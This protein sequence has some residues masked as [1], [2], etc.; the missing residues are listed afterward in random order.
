MDEVGYMNIW[1]IYMDKCLKE[2]R[3]SRTSVNALSVQG[4]AQ[5]QLLRC[6]C[7][8]IGGTE[9]SATTPCRHRNSLSLS[10]TVSRGGTLCASFSLPSFQVRQYSPTTPHPS[11]PLCLPLANHA[12]LTLVAVTPAGHTD[13]VLA[14]I[15]LEA[16]SK[17]RAD[18]ARVFSASL[19]NTICCWD[20]YDMTCIYKYDPLSPPPRLSLL[21]DA[22]RHLMCSLL[23]P[24]PDSGRRPLRSAACC[25]FPTVDC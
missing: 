2:L 1:N 6:V 19:D 9:H 18:D 13:A 12:A 3:I 7:A 5:V 11:L 17:D 20:P 15:H 25:T 14:L 10:A 24:S 4:K 16:P 8:C 22:T 23:P 21:L